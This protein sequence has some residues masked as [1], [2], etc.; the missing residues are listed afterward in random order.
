MK[1]ILAIVFIAL[2]LSAGAFAQEMSV[3]K[4]L[5]EELPSEEM[6]SEELSSE[7]LSSEELSSEELPSEELP[8]EELSS[9]ELPSEEL[10]S[11]ELSSEELPSEELPLQDIP[12]QREIRFGHLALV[13]SFSV[14]QIH[15]DNIYYGNGRNKT[16]EL[17]ESDWIRHKKPGLMLDWELNGRG[18]LKLGYDG[19]FA[20]YSRNSVNNWRTSRG[21]LDLDYFTPGGLIVKIKNIFTDAQDP[22]GAPNE[23]G[24]GRKTMRWTDECP[25]AVG[26]KFSKLFRVFAFYNFIKQRYAD[27]IDFTQNYTSTETGVGGEV[28]VADKTWLFLRTYSGRWSYDTHRLGVTSSN[29]PSYGWKKVTTGLT[30]DSAARFLGVV[31]I[32][33]QWNSFDNKADGRGLPYKDVS[34]WIAA[35]SFEFKQS[36]ARALQFTFS[37]NMVLLGSGGG[38]YFM[39]T[40]FGIGLRQRI[41]QRMVLVA[42]CAYTKNRYTSDYGTD[43]GRNDS[44][45]DARASLNYLLSNWLSVGIGVHQLNNSSNKVVNEYRVN[46]LIFSLDVNPEFLGRRQLEELLVQE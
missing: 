30:W 17:K 28:N 11:E 16:T 35:T 32:G 33:Y 21:L 41:M 2:M 4:Q 29:D 12:F 25:T 5:S 14:Q 10:P 39:T 24:L 44:I 13:P 31:D 19:D 26:F 20:S 23:Y 8:S 22:S 40:S 9:E 42:G 7:E 15:D 43:K 18:S 3:K 45:R 37:R 36:D 46:Q 27:R 6:S 34:S 1:K 38:G